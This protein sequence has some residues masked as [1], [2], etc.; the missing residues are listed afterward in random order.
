M[1]FSKEVTLRGV[2]I[3]AGTLKVSKLPSD[4]KLE[5][6]TLDNALVLLRG[7]MTAPELLTA[8][9]ALA[10]LAAELINHLAEVCGP[11]EDCDKYSC[12]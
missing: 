6:H 10:D 2:Y 11:C 9:H 8:A 3:T 5:L 4:K 7:Q 12:P 1:K